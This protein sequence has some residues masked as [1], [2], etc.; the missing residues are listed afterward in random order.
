[1]GFE[2]LHMSKSS[3]LLHHLKYPYG[4]WNDVWGRD[5]GP[6]QRIW[7]IPM[8]FE[9]NYIPKCKVKS[10]Y[11]KYPYGIWNIYWSLKGKKLLHLKYPYGIWNL[12]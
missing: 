4:I 6:Q 5:L 1:M 7:S 12:L 3:F 8:G 2:T 10:I 9:T 11:L